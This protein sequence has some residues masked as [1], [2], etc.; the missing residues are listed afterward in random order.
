[1]SLSFMFG[2]PKLHRRDYSSGTSKATTELEHRRASAAF[3]VVNPE[4]ACLSE[5]NLRKFAPRSTVFKSKLCKVISSPKTKKFGQARAII[6]SLQNLS[7]ISLEWMVPEF[8][9]VIP[10]I[11][12]TL[13]DWEELGIQ[14]VVV[15]GKYQS[16]KELA[17][18]SCHSPKREVKEEQRK[19]IALALLLCMILLHEFFDNLSIVAG[20]DLNVD[21][22]KLGVCSEAALKGA[23]VKRI[24]CVQ[25]TEIKQLL[26][27]VIESKF[28]WPCWRRNYRT[29]GKNCIDAVFSVGCKVVDLQEVELPQE[30]L[31]PNNTEAAQHQFVKGRIVF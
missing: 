9:I 14:C 8:S 29:P 6:R 16:S 30:L 19:E 23:L 4:I 27:E 18:V 15:R 12:A 20:C 10:F 13:H 1:M 22:V 3:D 26:K 17:I 21:L 7:S 11:G 25:S 28:S 2:N 24:E 5:A 31:A